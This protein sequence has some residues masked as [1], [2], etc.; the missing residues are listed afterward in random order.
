MIS[1]LTAK[2][3]AGVVFAGLALLLSFGCSGN[4]DEATDSTA[5]DLTSARY[6]NPVLGD[7]S[8]PDPSVRQFGANYFMVCTGPTF[9]GGT[10]AF[11]LRWSHDL[12]HWN[13]IGHVFTKGTHPK[14]AV[15]PQD[16]GRYWAP[17]IN[18]VGGKWLVTF[19]ATSNDKSK[20]SSMAI[21]AATADAIAGPWTATP[22]PI[23]SQDDG[24]EGPDA[25]HACK[26]ANVSDEKA[27]RIDP[28]LL[29]H[30]GHL[31]MYYVH[32]SNFVRVVELDPSGTHVI[33]GTN[34]QLML[35]DGEQF[36]ATLPWENTTVEGVEA[37]FKDGVFYLLYSGDSTWNGTYAVGVAKASSPLGPFTKKGAPILSTRTGSDLVGPGHSSQWVTGPNGGTAIFYHVQKRGHE[38]VGGTRM[39]CLDPV[40]FEDGW[41]H[42]GDGHPSESSHAVP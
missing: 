17:E 18:R 4:S 31:Y 13:D 35:N 15:A 37:H 29:S 39:P 38:G 25:P 24:S 34:K 3:T 42:I 26:D 36:H 7:I 5:E 33:P 22:E 23:V 28:T 30:D 6:T 10:D 11:A 20:C 27:G 40:T 12:V 19:A 9:G 41:P 21:G 1:P 16:G 32:Q 14:W 2:L 8:C